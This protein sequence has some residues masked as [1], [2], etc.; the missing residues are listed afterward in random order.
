MYDSLAASYHLIFEDWDASIARQ[1]SILGPLIES[2]RGVA[3]LK[4]L[5]AA[6]G[7]GTQALGLAMPGH[8]V[9][10]SDLSEGAIARA[11]DEAAARHL[12]I[13]LYAADMRDLSGVP[14][15]SF[16]AVVIADNALAHL[17][18][19]DD[20]QRAARAAAG[21]LVPGGVWLAT[22]RDFDALV[23]QRPA[24]Q[25]P[26]FYDDHGRRR[27]IY[28]VWDWT[29]ERH[30]TVHLHILLQTAGG[31]DSRHFTSESHAVSRHTLSSALAAAGFQS[32]RWM[33]PAETGLYQPVLL[34]RLP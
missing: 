15:G 27:I 11:R 22:L 18:T 13:P 25:G 33:E 34:A 16:D 5:D 20:V 24:S 28:Q 32:I 31:W 4:I 26:V 21:R 2:A 1:A 19:D 23:R 7:I 8:L 14:G 12:K 30:Y 17:L 10:G 9:T 3:P 6:C 29:A